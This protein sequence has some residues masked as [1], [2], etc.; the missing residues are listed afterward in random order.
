MAKVH[1]SLRI[2]EAIAERVKA[3]A[4]DGESKAATYGR[5]LSAGLEALEGDSEAKAQEP[6]EQAARAAEEASAGEIEALRDYVETLKAQVEVKDRQIETLTRITEQAQ[7]L[8]A[9]TER[10]N[11]EPPS[12]Q[13]PKERRRSWWSRHF[14]NEDQEG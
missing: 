5:V 2:E 4:K 1:E 3:Q 8:H 11:L 12:D 6:E 9:F 7:T 10:K 14:G 13:R